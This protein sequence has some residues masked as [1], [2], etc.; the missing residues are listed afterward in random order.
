MTSRDDSEAADDAEGPVETAPIDVAPEEGIDA[1]LAAHPEER[2]LDPLR[3]GLAGRA[4]FLALVALVLFIHAAIIAALLWRDSKDKTEVAQ[5]AETPVEVIV[6]KPP[7]PPKPPP[8]P[9]KKPPPPPPPKPKEE[10]EKP[11]LSAPRAPNE[12]KLETERTQPKTSAPK[13]PT[14]PSEGQ[15]QPQPAVAPPKEAAPDQSK[16]DAAKAPDETKPDAEALDKAKPKPSKQTKTK[17]AKAAPKRKQKPTNAL[18]ALAGSSQLAELSFAKPTPKT[19]IYG[20]TEDV[21]Y[22]AIVE[23]ML[24]A[25][26]TQL[27]RTAHW[28]DGGHVVIFFHLDVSGRVISRDFYERSGYPDIDRIAMQALNAAAPFPPPPAGLERGLVWGSKFDGQLPR[29][30]INKR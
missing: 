18:A 9:E 30:T 10:L 23:A 27:P 7:E 29:L 25:K 6:E 28:R 16:E 5:M 8:P 24:E 22:L 21:R 14:P 19:P 3:R 4:R 2:F 12:E 11:A 20:G 1:T 17:E 26:V 15:P 13:A